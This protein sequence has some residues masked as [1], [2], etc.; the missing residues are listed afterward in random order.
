MLNSLAGLIGGGVAYAICLFYTACSLGY[1]LMSTL[2]SLVR[3]KSALGGMVEGKKDTS[4][5]YI[6]YGA[7]AAQTL[8]L[9]WLGPK[10]A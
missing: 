4:R 2:Q 8:L 10:F 9:W 6:V 5:R 7:V 3:D 1:F